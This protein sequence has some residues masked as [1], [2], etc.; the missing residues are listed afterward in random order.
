[1]GCDVIGEKNVI[2]QMGR[3]HSEESSSSKTGDA[4]FLGFLKKVWMSL[5]MERNKK[6]TTGTTVRN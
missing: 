4:G 6:K 5:K 3:S 2:Q 1:M